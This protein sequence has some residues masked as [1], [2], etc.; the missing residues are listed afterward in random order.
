M[1]ECT[2]GG[3]DGRFDRG[4]N[5][6]QNYETRTPTK[7]WTTDYSI[8]RSSTL[9]EEL[10]A[11]RV[12]ESYKKKVKPIKNIEE[13]DKYNRQFRALIRRGFVD[14]NYY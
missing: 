7:C 11:H 4:E 1:V 9:P 2:Q 14:G 3:Y 12:R 8:F 10:E 5:T 13:V 6:K